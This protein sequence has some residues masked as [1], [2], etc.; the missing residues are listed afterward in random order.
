MRS[1]QAWQSQSGIED[2]P[3]FRSVTR[4]G[5]VGKQLSGRDVARIIKRA[6]KA[7]GLD[8]AEYSGH[9]LRAGLATVAA[10]AGKSDRAIM[11]QGRW[12]SRMMVDRYVREA[13]LFDENAASG[14]GL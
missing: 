6:A 5:N 8:S 2:G 14:I 12:K 10:K 4:H 9:S 3:V 1:L 11:R 7:A 13:T